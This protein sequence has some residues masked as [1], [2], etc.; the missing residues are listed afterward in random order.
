V[1]ALLNEALDSLG[2]T[3]SAL[4][5]VPADLA[6]KS[7]LSVLPVRVNT[8]GLGNYIGTNP[9]PIGQTVG[10]RLEALAV[11]TVK[12][13]T[14]GELNTPVT[15]A[16]RSVVAADRTLLRQSGILDISL[17]SVGPKPTADA[18]APFERDL[19]F[20]V[21]YEFLKK[22]AAG[23]GIIKEIPQIIATG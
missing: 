7:V 15:D 19:T 22:P 18:H 4:L 1:D 8:P 10:C 3:L 20:R 16:A 11:V 5:P 23:E 2:I 12:A 14:L 6:L 13:T 17:D 9:D 21:K